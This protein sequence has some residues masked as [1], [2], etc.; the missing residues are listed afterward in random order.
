MSQRLLIAVFLVA[1]ALF[2]IAEAVVVRRAT[3]TEDAA[4]FACWLAWQPEARRFMIAADKRHLLA[5]GRDGGRLP[6]GLA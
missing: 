6:S 1:A 5:I 4:T 3:P 2:F